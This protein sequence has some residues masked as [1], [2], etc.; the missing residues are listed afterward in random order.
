MVLEFFLLEHFHS[1]SRVE[2]RDEFVDRCEVALSH[3][4]EFLGNSL[5]AVS[6]SIGASIFNKVLKIGLLMYF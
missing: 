6:D 1:F 5:E 2:S 3:F 4:L